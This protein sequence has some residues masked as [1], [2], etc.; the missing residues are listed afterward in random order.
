MLAGCVAAIIQVLMGVMCVAISA[1]T[2][3]SAFIISS[4]PSTAVAVGGT[5]LG[6]YLNGIWRPDRGWIDRLGRAFGICW[7]GLPFALWFGLWN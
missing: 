5:W 1:K 2:P 7:L 3:L 4:S 6:A